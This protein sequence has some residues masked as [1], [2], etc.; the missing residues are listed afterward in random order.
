VLR[1]AEKEEGNDVC[2]SVWKRGTI[3]AAGRTNDRRTCL[4]RR[5]FVKTAVAAIAGAAGPS[6]RGGS[7]DA[8][9]K[10]AAARPRRVIFNNDG[11]DAFVTDAPATKEGFL[12]V[13]MDHIA[14]CGVDSLFYC[15]AISSVFTHDSKVL[16]VFTSNIGTKKNNRMAALLQMGT[17]PLRLAVEWGRRHNAEVFWTLRM[18]DIHDNWRKEIRA[19]WKHER[20]ELV[21]GAPDDAARYGIRDPR[22]IWTLAD[23][24]QKEVRDLMVRAIEEVLEQYD[25]DGIDLDFLRH[26]CYFKETRLYQPVTPAHRDMLTDMVRQV[27]ERVLA[28]SERKGR[29]VLLSARVLQTMALNQRFGLDLEKWISEGHLDLV[30]VGGGFDPFTSPGRELVDWCHARGVPAYGCI[31]SEGLDQGGWSGPAVPHSELS[32]RSQESWRAAAANTWAMGVD[33]VMTFNLFADRSGIELS[34]S[35]LREIGDPKNLAGKDKLYCIEHLLDDDYCWMIRSV[36]RDGRLPASVSKGA[37]VTRVLPVADDIP[38]LADRLRRL[39]LR[40]YLDHLRAPD[41]VSVRLNDVKLTAAP[42]K[43]QWLAADVAPHVMRKGPNQLA[44][45]FERGESASW[46]LTLRSVELS[47]QYANAAGGAQRHDPKSCRHPFQRLR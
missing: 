4:G 1:F 26:I 29:P 31:T 23:Y 13:R 40:L 30:T 7:S 10:D 25:V 14:D 24:A 43:P 45:A 27:R 38:N 47:V 39:R 18:N 35:V 41:K 44:V 3:M 12:S 32:E 21:M 42:E 28:A 17:D 19:R 16:E 11:N 2:R 15:T 33:G 22:H 36:P 46:T 34:R 9:R 6:T 20:P 5:R 37:T 8:A